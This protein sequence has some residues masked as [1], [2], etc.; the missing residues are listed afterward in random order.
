M[1]SDKLQ[2]KVIFDI[3]KGS[4]TKR[5]AK[6][7]EITKEE[8]QKFNLFREEAEKEIAPKLKKILAKHGIDKVDFK[9]CVANSKD[10]SAERCNS[11]KILIR[12]E[13]DK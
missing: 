1:K 13:R 3:V 7:S 10:S 4:L 11:Y 6:M 12:M 8:K 5:I 9:F 2:F